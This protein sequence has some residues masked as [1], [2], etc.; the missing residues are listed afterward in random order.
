MPVVGDRLN[1]ANKPNGTDLGYQ[2]YKHAA[3]ATYGGR[4]TV[5]HLTAHESR[6]GS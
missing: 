5:V 6:F 2:P 4:W 1:E 3:H